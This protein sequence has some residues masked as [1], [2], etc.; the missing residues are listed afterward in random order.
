MVVSLDFPTC[1]A[2]S[3]QEQYEEILDYEPT[4]DREEVN[5]IYLSS[6]VLFCGR[7]FEDGSV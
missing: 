7:W 2:G 1:S 5:V 4:P 3:T 6:G